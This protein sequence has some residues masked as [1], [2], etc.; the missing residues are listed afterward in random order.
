MGICTSFLINS[1][2]MDRLHN[3]LFNLSLWIKF[4]ITFSL[5]FKDILF[6]NHKDIYILKTRGKE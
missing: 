3:K 4:S 6:V 1:R 5:M 2:W